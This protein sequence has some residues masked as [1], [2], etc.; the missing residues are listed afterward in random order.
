MERIG[1]VFFVSVV[2]PIAFSCLAYLR[3]FSL[4][5]SDGDSLFYVFLPWLFRGCVI[6]API[7]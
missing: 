1:F 5:G 2:F 3:I 4:R 7:S 6:W